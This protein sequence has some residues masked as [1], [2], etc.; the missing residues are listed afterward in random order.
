MRGHK[1]TWLIVLMLC[2]TAA[3]AVAGDTEAVTRP[4]QDV[5][6]SFVR[7]G[8]VAKV[9]VKEGQTVSKGDLLVQQ[10]DSA[11]QAQFVQL[12]ES[13]NSVIHIDASKAQLEQK[14]ADL[15]KMK[16]AAKRGVAS[17]LEV[18]HARLD[19]TIADLS[20]K[21]QEFEHS[22]NLRKLEEARLQLERMTIRS[23]ISGQVERL[24]VEAGESV[25]AMKEVI[26]VVQIDPLWIETPVPLSEAR[27]LSVGD[28]ARVAFDGE[29][30]KKPNGKITHIA[31]VADAASDTLRVRVEAPNPTGRPAGERV[32][33]AFPKDASAKKAPASVEKAPKA[34]TGKDRKE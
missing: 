5:T 7:A 27:T 22:Q 4:S 14:K 20:L 6:L 17:A 21:L 2:A 15:E 8:R 32:T 26:R 33:V 3:A 31:S 25:D 28:P 18:E 11:E 1:L 10:D 24:Y 9:L 13:A 23:P 12:K 19:V 29:A 30:P 34:E 16:N